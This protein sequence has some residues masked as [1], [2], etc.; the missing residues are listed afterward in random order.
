M[1]TEGR[2]S[3][4]RRPHA[5]GAARV[6]TAGVSASLTMALIGVMAS[7]APPSSS[8]PVA[9]V[10]APTVPSTPATVP[11]PVPGVDAP[12]ETTPATHAPVATPPPRAAPRVVVPAAPP[13][14]RSHAS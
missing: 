9:A 4:R 13:V 6:L 1:T 14:T 8:P 12:A 5:A 7:E 10:T 2:R 11:P 3:R